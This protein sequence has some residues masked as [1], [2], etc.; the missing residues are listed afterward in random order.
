MIIVTNS[1]LERWEE[2]KQLRLESL[3][4]SPQSFLDDIDKTQEISKEEWQKKLENIYFAEMDG[5]WVGMI[6]AYQDERSKLNHIMKVVSF[7]VSPKYRGHGIGKALLSE[8]I[9]KS[10]KVKGV[11]K[12]E[13]GVI[14]TQEAAYQLYLTLGFKKVGEQKYSVRV[15]DKYFDEYLMELY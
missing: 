7:Y 14:T 11:K 5:K 4:D 10:K 2:Y 12:L 8:V 3:S 13:L 1:P 15:G 9:D 6:G